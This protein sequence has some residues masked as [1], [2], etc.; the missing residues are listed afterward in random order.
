[1]V[2]RM[3]AASTARHDRARLGGLHD[4]VTNHLVGDPLVTHGTRTETRGYV[5]LWIRLGAVSIDAVEGIELDAERY[6]VWWVHDKA[7]LHLQTTF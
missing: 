7:F 5:G 2:V 6:E 3:V 4:R 1:M